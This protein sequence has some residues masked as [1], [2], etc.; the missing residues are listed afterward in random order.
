MRIHGTVIILSEVMLT[1]KVM[2]ADSET[3]ISKIEKEIKSKID[4]KRLEKEPIAFGLVALKVSTAVMDAEG[5][6][7]ELEKK[8][9]SIEGV[10]EVEVTEMTRVL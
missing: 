5:V 4:V 3:D 7:D 6:V 8:L 1:F 9:R 10:G 2:P